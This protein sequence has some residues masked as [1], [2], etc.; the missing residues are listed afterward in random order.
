MKI[1]AFLISVLLA[2]VI[3]YSDAQ[4]ASNFTCPDCNGMTH[5]LF[6]EL[7]TGNVIVL[8]WVMPCISCVVPMQTTHSVVQGFQTSHPNKVMMYMCDDFAD[9]DCTALGDWA[10]TYGLTS[11]TTFSDTSIHMTDYGSPEMNKV[12]VIGGLDHKVYLRSDNAVN[13]T[14]LINAIETAISESPTSSSELPAITVTG[15]VFPNPCTTSVEFLFVNQGDHEICIELFDCLG[16]QVKHV[17]TGKPSD[18]IAH[19]EFKINDLP[20]GIYF[21]RMM[22]TDGSIPF[23]SMVIK[24]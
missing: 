11:I 12:V 14:D 1:K 18:A 19:F 6:T 15:T 7:D 10:N 20:K 17:F 21:L 24:Q 22:S 8:C 16:Q 3:S 4:V 13:E 5:D 9:T 2:V 23:S